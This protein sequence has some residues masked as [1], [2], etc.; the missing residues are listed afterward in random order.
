M[1]FNFVL[2]KV[3]PRAKFFAALFAGVLHPP[4]ALLFEDPA[5]YHVVAD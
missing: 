3:F 2:A 4:L 1:A 5:V